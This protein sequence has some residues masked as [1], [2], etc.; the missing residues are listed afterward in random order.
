M[1]RPT[2]IV[3]LDDEFGRRAAGIP[4]TARALLSRSASTAHWLLAKSLIVSCPLL[5]DRLILLFALLG[6]RWGRVT[7]D[8]ILLDLPLT[9]GLLASL[10]GARRPSVTLA[11]HALQ[12]ED[13][14][15]RADDGGWLLSPPDAARPCARPSCWQSYAEALGLDSVDGRGA[16]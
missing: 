13:V 2:R 11:L 16:G 7:S 1:L 4:V 15:T 14:L 9:H 6:E 8:G 10:C 3:L 5:E 12:E